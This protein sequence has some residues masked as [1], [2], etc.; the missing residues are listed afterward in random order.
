[1]HTILGDV[2]DNF[3]KWLFVDEQLRLMKPSKKL[4]SGRV[5]EKLIL[6]LSR[7]TVTMPGYGVPIG[8]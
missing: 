8:T 5:Q 6:Q 3:V 1:M 7:K 4:A 2:S